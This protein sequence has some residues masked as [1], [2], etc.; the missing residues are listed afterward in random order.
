MQTDRNIDIHWVRLRLDNLMT[1]RDVRMMKATEFGA[2]FL[3][4]IHSFYEEKRGY[5]KE[6]YEYLRKVSRL[7][8]R[9]WNRHKDTILSKFKKDGEGNL[10]NE[11]WI[12]EIMDAESYVTGNKVKTLKAR[13]TRQK[14]RAIYN[15]TQ[16]PITDFQKYIEHREQV[17]ASLDDILKKAFSDKMQITRPYCW[18][19]RKMPQGYF[20]LVDCIMRVREDVEWQS[21]IMLNNKIGKTQLLQYIYEF[22]KQIKDAQVYMS[23]D[24]YNGADGKDNFVSHF[25]RWLQA[26]LKN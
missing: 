1:S 18:A 9:Q 24:G 6:D 21:S 22:V 15:D 8:V 5:I 17:F 2:Y 4:L 13:E 23:Y 25:V 12:S 26:K 20:D 10:Y 19:N 16:Q 14:K 7:S 3:I 11:R